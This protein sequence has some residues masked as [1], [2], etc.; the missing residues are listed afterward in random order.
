M[1][2]D[3]VLSWIFPELLRDPL[4]RLPRR[5]DHDGEGGRSE[6]VNLMYSSPSRTSWT[7]NFDRASF[8]SEDDIRG[9]PH[10]WQRLCDPL[11]SRLPSNLIPFDRGL[12]PDSLRR[13]YRRRYTDTIKSV[14]HWGQRKLLMSEIEFLTDFATASNP[15][16]VLYVGAG[17]GHHLPI[18]MK[19]FEGLVKCWIFYDATPFS[20][21]SSKTVDIR[22]RYFTDSDAHALASEFPENLL[23]ICD[24]RNL[25]HGKMDAASSEAAVVDDMTMQERW[26]RILKPSKSMLKFRLPYVPGATEYLAGELLLPVWG[27]QT[28][29]ETRLVVGAKA[30]RRS[31]DHQKH[32]EQMFYFNTVTRVMLYPCHVAIERSKRLLAGLC[33][34]YDCTAE[35]V[36]L[37]KYIRRMHTANTGIL[38][39]SSS[40]SESLGIFSCRKCLSDLSS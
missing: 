1:D 23:F 7:E 19:M 25:A 22:N 14:V 16:V 34:C 13:V 29:T 2:V 35:L 31:Y 27:P 4:M 9:N 5:H 21:E 17:P 18:L 30:G 12:S 20:F 8:F 40:I 11:S 10:T 15:S 26:V 39:L 37:D 38:G 3:G 36:I 28:T 32:W 6:A 24:I 33:S